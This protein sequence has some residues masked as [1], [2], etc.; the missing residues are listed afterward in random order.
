MAAGSGDGIVEE[1]ITDL[2]VE[3]GLYSQTQFIDID[4]CFRERFLG[5]DW[6]G[7]GGR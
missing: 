2:T 3:F 4:F 7:M 6:R 1:E 5:I